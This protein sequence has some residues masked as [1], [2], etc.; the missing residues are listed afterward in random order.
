MS[1]IRLTQVILADWRRLRWPILLLCLCV[2][3]ALA[4]VQLSHSNRLLV[5][6]H[7]QLY[8]QRDTL[9]V[10][11]RNL[12]LEQRALSEHSRVEDIASS[13]LNMRRPSGEREVVVTLP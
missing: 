8:Q 1:Q 10:E 3:S 9:D 4:V 7:N 12:L 6:A 13:R 5:N 2:L 11:W